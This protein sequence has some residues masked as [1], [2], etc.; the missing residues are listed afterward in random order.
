M[1]ESLRPP[2][3]RL[4]IAVLGYIVRGPFGGMV[5]HH[6]QY[7]LGLVQLGHE[8]VYVEDSDDYAS[9]YDPERRVMDVDPSYGLRFAAS[10]FDRFGLSDLWAYRDAHAGRWHGPRGDDAVRFFR[11]ADL[12]L[13]L[14]G[15]NP[16]RPWMMD[17]PVRVL[18]DTDPGF[19]QIRHLTSPIDAE[20][21]AGHTAFFTFGENIALGDSAVPDDG[22]PWKA[23]RQP[24]VLEA[25]PVTPLPV[26]GFLT[27]VMNWDSYPSR[28]YAGV[29][30]GMKS[31]SF[32]PY[33]DLPSRVGARFELALGS[34]NATVERL[35]ASGWRLSDP[36]VAAADALS[37][38][39]FIRRSA[40]EFTVAK[41]G[42]VVGRTGWFSERSAAYL[43]S[44]RPVVVQ[45][46]EF[47]RWLEAG[48]G[49]LAFRTPYEA[50]GAIEEV[51]RR[52]AYHGKL[53]REVAETTFEARSVL[54]RLISRAM[55]TSTTDRAPRTTEFPRRSH[56]SPT[57]AEL[58]HAP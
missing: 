48:A 6:L 20:R 36:Q 46:T 28:V 8:V 51:L 41:H 42:Y 33:V 56:F 34:P 21:A 50:V 58:H 38:Q 45:D 1:A 13:N 3:D 31:E 49:V 2:S 19:T 4:R 14:S 32:E 37:Y 7:L 53:A 27:T 18:V 47:T 35:R 54:T 23:T 16:L 43:A 9:C 39:D 12:V 25:W 15:S 26:S 57:E 11:S 55:E 17:S 52:P 10:T 30:Y 22:L 44:G 24:I 29:S 40:G 5:W